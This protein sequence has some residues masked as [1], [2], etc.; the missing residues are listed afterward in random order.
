M[1]TVSRFLHVA[2]IIG[3]TGLFLSSSIA[4]L[5]GPVLGSDYTYFLPRLLYGYVWAV[6]NG[7]FSIPWYSPAWCGGLPY[8]A[9]PQVMYFSL[10]QLLLFAVNPQQAV[11]LTV[12][13]FT[14]IGS[15]ATYFLL[16]S[17]FGLGPWL[18]L[19]GAAL[20]AFNDFY[21]SRM[22]IGHFTY[23]VFPLIPLIALLVVA[24]T[25]R[26]RWLR[27][28]TVLL[29][30]FSIAYL[31]HGGG[32]NF[33]VPA[34]LSVAGLL[35]IYCI[36]NPGSFTR[37]LV[38]YFAAG[39]VGLLLSFSK[40]VSSYSFVR[41]FPREHLPLGVFDGWSDAIFSIFTMFFMGPWV[42]LQDLSTGSIV[43]GHELR[44][45]VSIVPFLLFWFGLAALPALSRK[46]SFPRMIFSVGLVAI[47]FL[48]V[49]LSVE[50][51]S[52]DQAL[53]QLPYFREMSFAVRWLALLIP[54]VIVVPLLLV[55]TVIKNIESDVVRSRS[56]VVI[57]LICIALLVISHLYTERFHDSPY[58]PSAIN[59]SYHEV[60]SG[61]SLPAITEIVAAA[62]Q[63]TI[64][65]GVDDAF[66]AGGS[67]QI[68]YQPLFGYKLERYPIGS[69]A[70]GDIFVTHANKLNLKNPAC[71]VYPAENNCEVGDHFTV[72]QREEASL[73][74]ANHAYPFEQSPLQ[75]VANKVSIL[76]FA[77]CI[78]LVLVSAI[79]AVL[80]RREG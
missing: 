52:I 25:G 73:F 24:E 13:S 4:L 1:T 69:L 38:N 28:L 9:D 7:L 60:R 78:V 23:H 54:I 40:I 48:P 42:V 62:P 49:G 5:L 53:K 2:V 29:A 31:V 67:S 22:L 58:D 74:A 33:V 16:R 18:S 75:V 11:W 56:V 44:F 50:S 71:Y 21:L 8:F 30:G 12:V 47:L 34:I 19:I 72:E 65:V 46:I 59:A 32:A 27:M 55:H 64:F 68:C 51:E 10:P 15:V 76:V 26:Q 36:V 14:A 41:W 70:T 66:L 79:G 57:A 17:P 39:F 80:S 61:G 45:G 6:E 77:L 35:C 20:F 63:A 37:L 43:Q 3:L